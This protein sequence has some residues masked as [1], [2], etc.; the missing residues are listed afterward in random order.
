MGVFITLIIVGIAVAALFK[1]ANNL[2]KNTS[3]LSNITPRSPLSN[4]GKIKPYKDKK[5]QHIYLRGVQ[6]YLSAFNEIN[7]GESIIVEI[8]PKN[9]N[10]KNAIVA[11][12]ESGNTLG[13]IEKG[14]RKLI[15]TLKENPLCF[16]RVTRKFFAEDTKY[17]YYVIIDL[18][19]GFNQEDLKIA[20]Q[21]EK[22]GKIEEKPYQDG[23]KA[24]R[25]KI[26]RYHQGYKLE[27]EGLID[28]AIELYSSIV[29]SKFNVP[30]SYDRLAIIYRKRK[31][32]DKEID[33]LNKLIKMFESDLQRLGDN[34]I[35]V[36][37]KLRREKAIE[38]EIC[39][40]K[41]IPTQ[42]NCESAT[43]LDLCP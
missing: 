13:Y 34:D 32:Y 43:L 4:G 5:F 1:S 24:N 21:P 36:Q 23:I 33:V 8:E 14:Q 22:K 41:S 11:K 3:R 17:K 27:R 38:P 26:N 20:I 30:S 39:N 40:R 37:A 6:H 25:N 2:E 9:P 12:T 15:L 10:D 7:K 42:N 29:D 19:V 18:F 16:A 31:Q 28:N 35:L